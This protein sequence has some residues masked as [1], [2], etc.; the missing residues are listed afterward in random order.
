MIDFHS[1]HGVVLKEK[2]SRFADEH[3]IQQTESQVK[4]DPA[5]M[6]KKVKCF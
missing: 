6:E 4:L 2:K 3:S 1:N 5:N